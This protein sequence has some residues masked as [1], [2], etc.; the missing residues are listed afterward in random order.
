MIQ[1]GFLLNCQN[2][3]KVA[4]K[5]GTADEYN[6]DAALIFTSEPYILVVETNDGADNDTLANISKAIY[7]VMK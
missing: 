7:E 2:L 6:H 1:K 5:I 3:F 4:H